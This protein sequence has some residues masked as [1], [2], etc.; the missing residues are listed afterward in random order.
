MIL[1]IDPGNE[2]SGVVLIRERDLKPIGA[3]KITNEE[4]LD[5]QLMDRY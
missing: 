3:E 5:N 2:Q 1:A 4:L